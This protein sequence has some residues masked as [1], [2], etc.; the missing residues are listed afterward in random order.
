[1]GE[2]TASF[3]RDT[4]F[5]SLDISLGWIR[6]GQT[7]VVRYEDLWRDPVRALDDLTG[8]IRAASRDRIERAIELCDFQLMRALDADPG[9]FRKGQVGNWMHALPEQILD[10][11]RH[12]EPYPG[13]FAALG[14]TLDPD[15]PLTT[16]P[17]VPRVSKNPFRDIT[18]FDNGVAVPPVVVRLYLSLE[19]AESRRWP[20]LEKTAADSFYAWLNAPAEQDARSDRAVTVTNL[21]RY[22]YTARPD[23]QAAFPDVLGKDHR[24]F[25]RWFMRHAKDRY[26]LEEAFIEPMRV[27]LDV[28]Q[29]LHEGRDVVTSFLRSVLRS[30]AALVSTK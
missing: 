28:S 24:R 30:L 11:L 1:M 8:S 17:R 12:V 7:R 6:S 16:L 15:D 5:Q 22:I 10:L 9:F 29:V 20:A 14:Y 3:V 26:D 13:Q 21:A 2:H 19:T 27:D 18:H 23:V 25:A 4:F